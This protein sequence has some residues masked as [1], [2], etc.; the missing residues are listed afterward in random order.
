[1][2]KGK[3]KVDW[4]GDDVMLIIEGVTDE[5]LEALALLIEGKAKVNIVDNDQV[6]TGFMLN[7]VYTVSRRGMHGYDAAASAA[8]AKSANAAMGPPATFADDTQRALV[9]VGAEYAIYQEMAN[10]FLYPALE[11]VAAG[12]GAVLQTAAKK[13]GL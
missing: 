4:Y 8:A 12:A 7:S 5:A 11:Q 3:S 13:A 2:A 10:P 1:M 9:A 6:D